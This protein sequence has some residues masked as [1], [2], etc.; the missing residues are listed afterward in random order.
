MKYA[1][2]QRTHLQSVYIPWRAYFH[3]R[4]RIRYKE[5]RFPR[6]VNNI[7]FLQD[8]LEF[9]V[10][11]RS[12]QKNWNSAPPPRSCAL[13]GANRHKNGRLQTVLNAP[14][15]VVIAFQTKKK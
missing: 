1:K 3:S 2:F 13:R 9:Y 12:C 15:Y 6:N 4:R 14:V 11:K 10:V 7:A 8:P 5:F